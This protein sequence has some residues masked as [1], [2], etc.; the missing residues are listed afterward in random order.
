MKKLKRFLS[1]MLTSCIFIGM[2]SD[3]KTQAQTIDDIS[4][5]EIKVNGSGTVVIDDGYSKYSLEDKD[6]LK[7]NVTV[8]SNLQLTVTPNEGYS[9]ASVSGVDSQGRENGN[10]RIY[11]ITT[12]ANGTFIDVN[13][14]KE[15][16]DEVKNEIKEETKDEVKNEI[17]EETKNEANEESS[18]ETVKE[19]ETKEE[20]K[21]IEERIVDKYH[22]GIY[23]EDFQ[24]EYR[25]NLATEKGLLDVVDGDYFLTTEFMTDKSSAY[26]MNE[27]IVLLIKSSSNAD[28]ERIHQQDEK[29]REQIGSIV[30]T[31]DSLDEVED[32]EEKKG[33]FAL[34]ASLFSTRE[35]ETKSARASIVYNNGTYSESYN[36]YTYSAPMLSVDGN[37]A[38]C[39]EMDKTPPAVG[40][41]SVVANSVRETTNDTL[42]KILYYGYNG[43][44]SSV[45][46]AW[47]PGG[48]KLLAVITSQAASYEYSGSSTTLGTN[49]HN[50]IKTLAAPPSGFKVYLADTGSATQTV[51]FWIYEKQGELELL[52]ES[53]DTTITK[54]NDYYSLDGAEY[55]VYTGASATGLVGTLTTDSNG[56]SNT[57]TL[58]AGIYYIKET[59]APKG[60]AL[61][62]KIHEV[63]VTS[64]A[65]TTFTT[66]DKPQTDP[67]GVLLQ[68]VDADTG[69]ASPQGKGTLADAQ[70]TF[71]FYAG[72]YNDGVNPADLGVSPTR[73]W[74]MKTDANGR[75]YLSDTY[76]VSGDAFYYNGTSR[77]TL[78]LG[79]LTVQETKAPVGYKI[80][81]ELFVIKITPDG[82]AETVSTFN[83]PIVKEDSL[84]FTIK[85]VQSGTDIVIA[86]AKF[87]HTNPDGSTEDLQTGS[88]GEVVIRGLTQGVHKIVEYES[89]DGYEVNTNEFIFEVKGDNSI[90]VK[91][92]TTNMGMSYSELD[93]DGILTVG[94]DVKSYSLRLTKVNDK[95]AVLQG[96]E[97]TLYS[98]KDCKNPIETQVSDKNGNLRFT[99]LKPGT[100]YYMKETK[101]PQGYKIP[102]D[103]F[104]NVH[105]YEIYVETTPVNN[106]FDYYIDGNKY[107]VNDTN[108]NNDIYLAGTKED[109]EIN[110]K[111]INTIG[112]KLPK[113]GSFLMIP[114]VLIGIA[115][116]SYPVIS[117]KKKKT[118]NV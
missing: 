22:E 8:N 54:G 6:S 61:D 110:M 69:N 58:D 4:R 25:K 78:P 93:G 51:G 57:L 29:L 60:Y 11:D 20:D 82:S 53:A 36:G 2:G 38:F 17:K 99:K 100:K 37:T 101:A 117:N 87:R 79:T 74:V 64:G 12:K 10:S 83:E 39:F 59:K 19:E 98:D 113:T 97:F 52:K 63:T 62:T 81:S 91:S 5:L 76:K 50:Y 80:N 31:Y 48:N 21:S 85:K 9:I 32:T 108:S 66:S 43:P 111:I 14:E 114:L 84:K 46:A 65:K 45:G 13:F 71:K 1:L 70:F 89:P 56:K 3:L 42:R 55:G 67:V 104:G 33:F 88:N 7:A 23:N 68:K 86:N 18:Q 90:E 24:I 75:T 115:L 96:A 28:I 30:Y 27:G 15:T 95:G 26:Y 72:E 16:K 102:V 109:R 106:I 35:A 92:N 40:G 49:F 73:T 118:N 112:M 41:G 47:C 94:N 116:M 105:V 34:V 77:P 107:T 44:E 103:V